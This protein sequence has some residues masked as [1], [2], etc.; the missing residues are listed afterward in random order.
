[1]SLLVA[2]FEAKGGASHQAHIDSTAVRN[3]KPASLDF[4]Q[5]DLGDAIQ[6]ALR[7]NNISWETRKTAGDIP[8]VKFR[9]YEHRKVWLVYKDNEGA[10]GIKY[11]PGEPERSVKSVAMA[12]DELAVEMKLTAD[13]RVLL[14]MCMGEAYGSVIAQMRAGKHYAPGTKGL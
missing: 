1:M 6:D 4:S 5:L 3:S 12:L 11:Y 14:Q 10:R 9:T 13:H 7:D 2:Y 8:I